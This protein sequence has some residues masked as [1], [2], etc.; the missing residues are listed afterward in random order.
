VGEIKTVLDE[1]D[2]QQTSMRIVF[3][4]K[5]EQAL[6]R[7]TWLVRTFPFMNIRFDKYNYERDEFKYIKTKDRVSRFVRE[8]FL[9]SAEPD[10]KLVDPIKR[11]EDTVCEIA[12]TSAYELKATRDLLVGQLADV[13]TKLANSQ[14]R[15]EDCL[16]EMSRKTKNNFEST[17]EATSTQLDDVGSQVADSK[18]AINEN[19]NVLNERTG[20]KMD[21]LKATYDDQVRGLKEKVAETGKR[22]TEQV[23]GL[24]TDEMERIGSSLAVV[25]DKLASMQDEI[26]RIRE[27]QDTLIG[28]NKKMDS[29]LANFVIDKDVKTTLST[30]VDQL[31][32]DDDTD[33]TDEFVEAE[34]NINASL[35]DQDNDD[36]D[37]DD[38]ENNEGQQGGSNQ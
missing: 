4:L 27:K 18:T 24:V 17:Q 13:E 19:I 36:D 21:E 28:L 16:V 29:Q 7:F 35:N 9:A 33:A 26:N 22:L 2:I 10:I 15:L 34:V 37:D 6:G 31:V 25:F 23:S 32:D 1:A 30:V 38:D 5:I 11:L 3:V 8:H 20:K 12:R 14:Q